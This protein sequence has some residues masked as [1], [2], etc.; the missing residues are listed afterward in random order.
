MFNIGDRVREKST[1]E[2]FLIRSVHSVYPSCVGIKI[3]NL[4]INKEILIVDPTFDD[5]EV[6]DIFLFKKP[7]IK[8]RFNEYEFP[9]W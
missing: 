6:V 7:A 8:H 3:F 9:C 4:K 1:G 2:E 5:Y